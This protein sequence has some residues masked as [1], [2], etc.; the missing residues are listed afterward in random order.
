MK[1]I[2]RAIVFF[3]ALAATPALA[4]WQVAAHAVPIGRGPG[5]TGFT[6]ATT[7]T[8]GR[9][10]IDQG[11][12]ADPAFEQMT[13]D[14]SIL[15]NG[16]ITCSASGS[17]TVTSVSVVSANGLAGTVANPTTTPAITLSTTVTGVL[18]GNGTTISAATT[19][20]TGSVVLSNSP[21]LVTPALG[22][23][24]AAVLTSATGLPLTTGVTGNL[25]VTNL[26]S[27]T[28]ATSSSFWRGD[29]TWATPSGSGNVSAAG[30][31][32]NNAIIIGSGGTTG[33]ATAAGLLTDGTSQL[34]LG[35]SGTSVG[36]VQF[37]NGTSGSITVSP[38]TGALG[39]AALTWPDA[40]D[41]LVG[42]A[43]T[44]TLTNKSISGSSN[45]LSSIANASLVNSSITIAG[46][47]VALGGTQAIACADLSNGATGCSTATGTS[48]AT[49]P[50]LNAANT[51]S[52]VQSFNSGDMVLKGSTSG[53]LT[54]NAAATAGSNTLT[55][56]AGTTNF[57]T[58][59]GTSQ[60]VKQTT[61][62]GAL[63]VAQLAASD[64]SNGT[65]GS[66][67]VCL[68]TS[69][70]MTTPNLGTPSAVTLTSGTGLPISTGVSGLGTGVA[71]FLATPTSANLATAVTD[72][73][74]SGA[75]V[76]GTS[77]TLV[78]PALGTP[79]ALVLTNATA[80]P[81]AGIAS[82]AIA[83]GANYQANAASTL[84]GPNAVWSGATIT[85][86]T[87]A[88]TIAVDL[89]TGI[90]FSVTVAGNRTLGN[91]T[92]AKV[93]QTGV[94]RVTQGAGGSHTLA[95]GTD[96]KWPGGT[97]CVLSTTAAV[98]DYVFYFVFSSTE[99]LLSCV[100]NVS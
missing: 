88:A 64:L 33:V 91:P 16:T 23:P 86:L 93:G 75:L 38:P 19:T 56:P 1:S 73:T 81:Y 78:T 46:H 14:C 80:L 69:C 42:R 51:W 72:E 53:T 54:V 55:F 29:G 49:I 70:V 63:T 12:G 35:V 50:L 65:S 99:I 89:S 22:T 6:A 85:A 27:G 68:T 90:N 58:T 59:G 18:Q 17:G 97:A 21:A 2:L 15:S 67:S 43:T 60:V 40:T 4:Q 30:N 39:S 92:N 8:S 28:G 47:N 31:L 34:Q 77:P 26:N 98:N 5:I 87:D 100:L 48:G 74:G 82:G 79:S 3:I 44:D 57:S 96:Y 25:P 84:L 66:G 7:G 9:L 24:S 13:G 36:S 83:T 37:N 52:G 71:T 61:S 95:Y 20:G 32:A 41:T 62:G 11:S 94:F 76:F 10:L 45:T